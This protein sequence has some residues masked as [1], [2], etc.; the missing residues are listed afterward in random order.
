[1]STHYFFFNQPIRAR[2]SFIIATPVQKADALALRITR[3][4]V[5][6]S[7]VTWSHNRTHRLP[8]K[9]RNAIDWRAPGDKRTR[10][11]VGH[12]D[13]ARARSLHNPQSIGREPSPKKLIK[14]SGK[15]TR[16]AN[17]PRTPLPP[18]DK[19]PR[20]KPRAEESKAR[21]QTKGP[22]PPRAVIRRPALFFQGGS[23]FIVAP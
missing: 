4:I 17:A 22:L 19:K 23:R 15:P 3:S 18:P 14:A 11:G 7:T 13:L 1:M 20:P 5:P 6:G 21:A 8:K 10:T 9:K 12:I 2:R 16:G